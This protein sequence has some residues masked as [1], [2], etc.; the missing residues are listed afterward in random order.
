MDQDL[1]SWADGPDVHLLRDR[2]DAGGRLPAGTDHIALV[3]G[4]EDSPA[5]ALTIVEAVRLIAV[6]RHLVG[7]FGNVSSDEQIST[8]VG[9][10]Q[11]VVRIGGDCIAPHGAEKY[12]TAATF[13]WLD[14]CHQYGGEP[15][16]WGRF[17][18]YDAGRLADTIERFLA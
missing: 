12:A 9:D 15:A 16:T 3:A 18:A 7:H 13:V 4:N 14:V 11:V 17:G 8:V 1:F 6:L 10:L 2:G 5:L